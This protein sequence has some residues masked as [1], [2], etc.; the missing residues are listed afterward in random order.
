ANAG[1]YALQ[2]IFPDDKTAEDPETMQIVRRLANLEPMMREI[3]LGNNSYTRDC[4]IALA[5][6]AMLA[7]DTISSQKVDEN[8]N[9][10]A[11]DPRVRPW[12]KMAVEKGSFYFTLAV[13]SYYAGLPEIEY[14]MPIYVD[15][16][17]VAVLQGP[18]CS[19]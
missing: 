10:H 17:L 7:M 4:C 1:N 18:L 13:S 19:A 16:E 2:L 3:V 9:R 12:Y 6:G 15:G 14:G 11:F 8:G 5:N